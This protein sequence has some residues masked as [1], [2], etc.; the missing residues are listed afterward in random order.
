MIGV[1]ATVVA[2]SGVFWA[3]RRRRAPD[4]LDARIEETV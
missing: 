2:G 1:G 4:A 3:V